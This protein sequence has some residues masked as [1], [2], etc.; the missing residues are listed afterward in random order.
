MLSDYI[1]N[2]TFSVVAAPGAHEKWF[3]ADNPEGKSLRELTGPAI[4]PPETWRSGD[5]RIA[6]LDRQGLHAATVF[7]TLA[8]VIEERI[9][10]R[11]DVSAALM[12][13]LNQWTLE[14]WGYAREN[15][16][17]TVPFV[18]LTNVEQAVKELDFLIENGARAVGIRPAPVPDIRGSRSFGFEDYDPFWARIADAGIFVCLHSSDSGY[19]KI[20]NGWLGASSEFLPFE[21][22]PFKA[23]VDTIG[24]AI[25]D[26]LTALICHGV[27][28]RHPNVRVVVVENGAHWLAPLL[29]RLDRAYGQIPQGFKQHPRDA[30]RKH[31]FVAPFYEDDIP[32]LKNQ[33]PVERILFGS[34]YPHP[35][36][37]AEPLD[38]IKE[39]AG[40]K[41]DEI[42][43]I[44]S[45]NL[46][47]LLEGA[48]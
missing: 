3:R 29:H 36:G 13:S 37:L 18:S 23:V 15:R 41:P 19:D 42:Q 6:M 38:Y 45:S 40:Y 47:G 26:S 12:H 35:E 46:K 32:D 21:Y 22:T 31:I 44:F 11:A 10:A 8:S 14:E 33:I 34:D 48:R 1:P 5:G 2:P 9:G 24:R 30:F 7:P 20:A 17:F 25:S 4:R 27:F 39:F 43:K 16:L 28:D